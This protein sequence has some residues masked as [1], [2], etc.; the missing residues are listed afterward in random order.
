MTHGRARGAGKRFGDTNLR[1]IVFSSSD[2][3]SNFSC[4]VSY[5]PSVRLDNSYQVC[6]MLYMSS[7]HVSELAQHKVGSPGLDKEETEG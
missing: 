1:G 3:H 4:C 5:F 7:I 2:I 6:F